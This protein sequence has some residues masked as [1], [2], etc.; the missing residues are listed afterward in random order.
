[1]RPDGQGGASAMV[2]RR[3]L[4]A[5]GSQLAGAGRVTSQ[6]RSAWPAARWPAPRSTG[7][8]EKRV[9]D[10]AARRGLGTAR[11]GDDGGNGGGW[12]Q[13]LTA[14]AVEGRGGRRSS[15][16]RALAKR[17]PCAEPQP[18]V[19]ARPDVTPQVFIKAN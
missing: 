8:G 3:A 18:P 19:M 13:E 5:G 9:G 6:R 4:T 15:A 14:R 7:A 10:G 1:V 17:Q 11:A 2:L 16:Y 12:T